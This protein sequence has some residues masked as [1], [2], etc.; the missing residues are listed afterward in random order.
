MSLN[1]VACVFFILIIVFKTHF[2][3]LLG[4]SCKIELC[5]CFVSTFLETLSKPLTIFPDF[6][7]LNDLK[8]AVFNLV[9]IL[10]ESA[11]DIEERTSMKLRMVGEEEIDF[12]PNHTLNASIIPVAIAILLVL[13]VVAIIIRI[14]A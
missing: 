9:A 7:S 5:F 3:S 11:K 13:I 1:L 4:P 14:R 12:P 6:I 10:I 8:D 2:S